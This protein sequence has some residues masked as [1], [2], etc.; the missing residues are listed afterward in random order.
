MHPVLFQLGPFVIPTYGAVAAL[1]VF[2]ALALAQFTAKRVNLDPRHAWNMLVL[3]IF[4]ALAISRLLLI[5]MNLSDLRR[6]PAWLLAV[7]MVHHPLLSAAGIV[8]GSAAVLAYIRWAKLPIRAVADCL[9]APLSLG[10]AAEQLGALLAGS[11]YGRE[12]E[13]TS[14]ATH[15]FVVYTNPLAARWS[16]APLN[17]AVYPVQVYAAI[18]ALAVAVLTFAGLFYKRRQPGDIAG[19]WLIA[20]GIVLFATEL[21]RDWEGRGVFANA[22]VDTPQLVALGMVLCGGLLLIDWQPAHRTA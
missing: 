11:D 18:G 15:L 13:A 14:S 8:A 1:G 10:M 19:I 2:L 4:A 17:V 22:L 20:T 3:A 21:F 12:I 5:V 6:H 7:A 16:G 9:A